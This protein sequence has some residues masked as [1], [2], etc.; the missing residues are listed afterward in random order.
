MDKLPRVER[1]REINGKWRNLKLHGLT[2]VESFSSL[3]R[4]EKNAEAEFMALSIPR[5]YGS[6]TLTILRMH[7]TMLSIRTE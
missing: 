6:I 1:C 3:R 2:P 7:S 4:C 5:P